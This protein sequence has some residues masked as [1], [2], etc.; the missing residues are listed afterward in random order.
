MD[1]VVTAQ[2]L[3]GGF[4][5]VATE[6][7]GPHQLEA[8]P[9][10][11]DA[12]FSTSVPVLGTISD[13][14]FPQYGWNLENTGSNFYNQ[15]GVADADVDASVGWEGGTGAGR[16]VAVVDSGFDSDH[17]DLAGAL[18]TNPAERCGSADTDR[19]G[20][21]GDCHGWNFYDQQRRPRQRQHG[22]AR[23]RRL[24]HRRRPRR[25]RRGFRRGRAG[26]DDHASGHRRR[27]DR[28]RPPRGP[29]DPLRGR[30]RRRRHQRLV[31]RRFT[32]WPLDGLRSAVAYA[33][34]HDVLVVAAAGNDAPT[35]TARSCTPRA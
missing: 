17:P 35:A 2:S 7:L 21:A 11:A 26:R 10:V 29:G 5:L 16:I 3:Y 4:A 27:L 1:G 15:T 33:A 12:E 14:Y 23:H 19:N 22:L 32:G 9:G 34:A 8:V 28:R 20:L 6:G 24:R 18:W 30:P 25:Q 31:G 13:P